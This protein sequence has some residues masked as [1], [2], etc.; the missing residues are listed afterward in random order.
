LEEVNV[1]RLLNHVKKMDKES[2]KTSK[3]SKPL[4]GMLLAFIGGLV[5]VIASALSVTFVFSGLG[6][7]SMRLPA[8]LFGLVLGILII[9]CAILLYFVPEKTRIIYVKARTRFGAAL[10]I[11]PV[12]NLLIGWD[13]AGIGF[14]LTIIGGIVGGFKG[15]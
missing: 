4:F 9:L 13:I 5:I 11:L 14:I 3:T 15:K 7:L 8:T 6:L 12:V 10:I 1:T 2:E